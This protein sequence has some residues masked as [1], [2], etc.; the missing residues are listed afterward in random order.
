MNKF[1][2]FVELIKFEHTI[3]ALP[4]AYIGMI[5]SAKGWPGFTVFFWITLA[6]VTARTAGMTLNRIIDLNIDRRNPRTNKR[7]LVTGEFKVLWA[8]GVVGVSLIF[9]FLSAA[10]LNPLC[11]ALSPV[12]LVFLT[13][14]HYVKRFSWLCHFTLGFV[15]AIAPVGGWMAVTGA[16]DWRAII[17][18]ASVL[19]WVAGFDILYALQDVEFDREARLHSVPVK[20]GRQKALEISRYCHLA[21][22]VFLFLFGLAC[23]FGWLYFIGAGLVA[24]LLAFEHHMIR[25]GDLSKIDLVF[26]TING[27]I[28][29]LL[30]VFTFMETYR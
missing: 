14:Y 16:F 7:A 5:A 28:G 1:K 8:W 18:A 4:F 2:T 30:L 24:A 20:F 11:L 10:R 23:G 21:T 17:L 3:F 26:F 9:F 6:M 27:W 15:L 25:E 13:G 29:I 22:A 19:A 12:A